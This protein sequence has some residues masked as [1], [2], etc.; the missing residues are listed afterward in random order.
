MLGTLQNV[1]ERLKSP[2]K[3]GSLHV[4]ITDNLWT[5]KSYVLP[6]YRDGNTEEVHHHFQAR[7][8]EGRRMDP[9][10][11]LHHSQS[12]SVRLYQLEN[13]H[14]SVPCFTFGFPR[15]D[16]VTSRWGPICRG[17]VSYDL[18]ILKR[19]FTDFWIRLRTFF[20]LKGQSMYNC[21][22]IALSPHLIN[23]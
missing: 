5:K 8:Q 13:H 15:K 4:V 6:K 19:V 9:K 23:S 3:L 14:L 2:L 10:T 17:S 11:H 21:G 16:Q 22:L 20:L 12:W 18:F 7:N 1:Y